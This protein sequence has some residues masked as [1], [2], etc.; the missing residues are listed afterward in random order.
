MNAPRVNAFWEMAAPQPELE[1]CL[2][3][4]LDSAYCY[5]VIGCFDDQ[6]FGYFE[7]YWAAEDRI[8]RHYRWQPYDRGLHML[9]GEE[10]WRALYSQLAARTDALSVSRRAPYAA[11]SR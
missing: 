4:Q 10:A 3:K 5:P 1:N 11:H 9:V 7:I 6:P 8:G 2:R